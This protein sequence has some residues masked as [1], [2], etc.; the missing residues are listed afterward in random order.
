MY[1]E[2]LE[3]VGNGKPTGSVLK[4]TIAVSA[5]I[6][7]NVE[8]YT[9]KSACK[10]HA[11]ILAQVG[12]NHAGFPRLGFSVIATS[13][14]GEHF[15]VLLS[16]VCQSWFGMV[17]S[18]CFALTG[19]LQQAPSS[20][21]GHSNSAGLSSIIGRDSFAA[22]FSVSENFSFLTRLFVV[23]FGFVVLVSVHWITLTCLSYCPS[24]TSPSKFLLGVL[25]SDRFAAFAVAMMLMLAIFVCF[26]FCG[27]GGGRSPV[28]A[29]RGSALLAATL[30]LR[31]IWSLLPLQL[32]QFWFPAI[33]GP[34]A[35]TMV[36]ALLIILELGYSAQLLGEGLLKRKGQSSTSVLP[37]NLKKYDSFFP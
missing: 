15:S 1:K 27:Y 23:K 36:T 17:F 25:K 35:G 30:G 12:D 7:I 22:L 29:I 37:G 28:S 14:K 18:T 16:A 5:T 31:H 33:L 6:S 4:E 20:L 10:I 2:F 3:I 11:A 32:A 34:G 26:Q 9:T 8:N 21:D 24:V 19:V 13:L